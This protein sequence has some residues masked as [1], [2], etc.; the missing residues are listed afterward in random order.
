[1][2]FRCYDVL[3][4]EPEDAKNVEAHSA[5]AAAEQFAARDYEGQGTQVIQVSRGDVSHTYEVE[6]RLE[7]NFY[8]TLKED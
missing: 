2:I 3:N 1:M 5:H 7:T 4:Q 8:A 6:A